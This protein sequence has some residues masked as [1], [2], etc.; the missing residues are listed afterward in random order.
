MSNKYQ[1]G[2][3]NFDAILC[4]LQGVPVSNKYQMGLDNDISSSYYHK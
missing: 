3:D 1:M 2:L 4:G